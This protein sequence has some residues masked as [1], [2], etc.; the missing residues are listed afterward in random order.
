MQNMPTNVANFKAAKPTLALK[1]SP[2][3]LNL[4]MIDGLPPE[5][6]RR[7][8]YAAGAALIQLAGEVK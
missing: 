7:R 4:I 1:T 2:V 6:Q 3:A 5:E 8:L